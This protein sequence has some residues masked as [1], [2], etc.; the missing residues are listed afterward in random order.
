M[1]LSQVEGVLV[2]M[3]ERCLS[4]L[5]ERQERIQDV[6]VEEL[7]TVMSEK[8]KEYTDSVLSGMLRMVIKQ[9]KTDAAESKESNETIIAKYIQN[10][11]SGM[12]QYRAGE[13]SDDQAQMIR[14]MCSMYMEIC[15]ALK[16]ELSTPVVEV[17]QKA[18]PSVKALSERN[19]LS[20]FIRLGLLVNRTSKEHKTSD[21]EEIRK[22]IEPHIP[23]LFV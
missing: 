13:I 1:N 7:S 12:S 18:K 10:S 8:Y 4:C 17:V 3:S 2:R 15:K 6:S 5:T 20:M 11:K 21:H 22:L 14:D 23:T 9:I 16:L 19:T